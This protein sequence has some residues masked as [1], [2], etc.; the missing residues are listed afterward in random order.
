MERA[1]RVDDGDRSF[2]IS[3]VD[4]DDWDGLADPCPACGGR[5]FDHVATAG[6]RYGVR[7]GAVVSRSDFWDAERALWTR[8]RGC[9]RILYK[10][11][12]ADLLFDP[13][14]DGGAAIER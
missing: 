3:G 14:E 13:G 12:A 4:R 1:L 6:G 5:E 2:T 10:H 11:P 9:E 7:D 8:C